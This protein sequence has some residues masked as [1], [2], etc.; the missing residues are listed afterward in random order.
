MAKNL[1]VPREAAGADSSPFSK[2]TESN[3]SVGAPQ[4]SPS[5]PETVEQLSAIVAQQAAQLAELAGPVEWLALRAC[6]RGGYSY[7]TL[8]KWCET[9]VIISRRQGGRIFVNTRSLAAHLAQ[10]GLAKA[11]KSA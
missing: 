11:I 1:Q 4:K 10:L 6:S 8:R 5:L 9:N 3:N 7:E 2:V